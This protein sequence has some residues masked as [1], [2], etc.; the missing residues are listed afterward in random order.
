MDRF[1][2]SFWLGWILWFSG[3]FILAAIV[4]TLLMEAFF[5][6]IQ[7][8]ELT[9]SWGVAVFGSW[10]ILLIPFMRK[11]EQIWKRLN[12]DQ[13]RAVDVW[14]VAMQVFIGSLIASSLLWSWLLRNQVHASPGF[15]PLWSKVVFSSW[16]FCLIPFLIWM[17]RKADEISKT[18]VARQMPHSPQFR[19]LSVEKSKRLLPE[20]IT[21]KLKAI[22]FTLREG[23]LITAI[24]KDGR[25]IPHV[26]VLN[27]HEI[28]GIYDRQTLDFEPKELADIEPI[29]MDQLPPFESAKW[30]KLE[31]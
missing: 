4:W 5:G 23:H 9:F 10:F 13:E 21:E 16:L 12:E 18:A 27:C 17:Y 31:G 14:L 15:D 8:R 19:Q 3:S 22:P 28:V 24:L 2:F 7:G 25:R 30:L 20:E 1:G 29:P 26:F 6:T 11:K